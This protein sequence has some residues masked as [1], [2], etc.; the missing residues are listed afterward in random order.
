MG[1]VK[2]DDGF[3][4]HPKVE[5]AGERAAWLY[6]CGLAYC[7]RQLT[8]GFIP[9][10]KIGRLTQT[11]GE[12]ALADRLV[13]V[14]LWDRADDGYRVHDYC[15]HQRSKAQVERQRERSA[16]RMRDWRATQEAASNGR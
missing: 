11:T 12:R 14:G 9:D 7:S 1:W 3:P 8:D 15:K 4:E 2:L 6:V 5:Q 13:Q 10:Q 16:A